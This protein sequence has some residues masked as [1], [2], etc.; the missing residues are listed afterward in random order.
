MDLLAGIAAI[1]TAIAWPTAVIV[2]VVLLRRPLRELLTSLRALKV[3]D[4]VEASFGAD[5]AALQQA[6]GPDAPQPA[7]DELLRLAR[8]S[9]RAAVLEAWIRLEFAARAALKRRGANLTADELRAPIRLAGALGE[10]GL[11]PPR[12]LAV[13]DELRHLRNAATHAE[14]F[15]LEPESAAG[16]AALAQGLA[17]TLEAA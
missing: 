10:H 13:F 5:V 11:L 16:Y 9:P 8:I 17:D 7:N 2:T 3:N 14:R 1:L 15:R 12:R 6:A 4:L